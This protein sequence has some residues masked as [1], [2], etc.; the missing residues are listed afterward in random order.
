MPWPMLL[1]L[2]V[3]LGAGGLFLALPGGRAEWL[4]AGLL[5]LAGAAAALLGLLLPR[6]GPETSHA[7]FTVLV[8]I[9]L[10]AAIRVVTHTRAV[11]SA[12]YFILVIICVAGLLLLMQAEFLAAALVIIYAGAIMVTYVFVIMLA[13]QSGGPPRYDL[14]AREPL[15]GCFAGF[16]L[17][18]AIGARAL[19]GAPPVSEAPRGWDELAKNGDAGD[20][21]ALV[22]GSPHGLDPR[23]AVAGT[24]TALGTPLLTKYIIGVEIAGVLL[25]AAMVGALAI[26]RRRAEPHLLDADTGHRMRGDAAERGGFGFEAEGQPPL[27]RGAG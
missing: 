10:W 9:G 15:W 20:G 19:A 27:S 7:V 8:V 16:I 26:A 11:Y 3:A 18:A 22:R 4:R 17:L 24:V 14:K 21:P 5:L 13:Q 25:L 6:L 23:V 2:M 12:L 1:T